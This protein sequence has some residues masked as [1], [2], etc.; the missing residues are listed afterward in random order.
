L[1][2]SS[3]G[4]RY[5]F[6]RKLAEALKTKQARLERAKGERMDRR[7]FTPMRL[8]MVLLVVGL[9]L[10][11]G[12][13]VAQTQSA[14]QPSAD[15]PKSVAQAQEAAQPSGDTPGNAAEKPAETPETPAA[16]AEAA[17]APAADAAAERTL[18]RMR[19]TTQ[20]QREAAAK[21]NAKRRAD[22]VKKGL[23]SA[24]QAI[25]GC[26]APLGTPCSQV[27]YFGIVP[28]YALS[29]LP[30][31]TQ[32][33]AAGILPIV[34]S[35]SGGIRKFMDTLPG[36][37]PAN[38]STLGGQ[39]IP[40]ASPTVNP[41]DPTVSDY[42]EIGLKD[43]T[44]QFHTNLPATTQV[45]GYYDMN[46]APLA[47][48]GNLAD[49]TPHYLG[50]VIIAQGGTALQRRPV[51]IKFVNQ[52][53]ANSFFFIP[54]D[55]SY[56]GMSNMALNGTGAHYS[57][58]RATLHLHGG[59][60]PWISDGTPHQWTVPVAEYAT[61][62]ARTTSD[63]GHNFARGVSAA[64]VP[65]MWFSAAGAAVAA[66][67][68]AS[69]DPGPGMLPF[70]YTNAQ[71]G[72]LMFYHDHSLGITR[73]N[74][75]AG[76]AAGY[77]LH[78][79]TEDALIAA[80]GA[81]GPIP[82]NAGVDKT[83][84]ANLTAAN[85]NVPG[86]LYHFGIPLIIQDKTFV[87]NNTQ[88]TL[89]D[90]SWNWG[91]EGNLWF[92]HVY[93]PN[94]NPN[95]DSGATQN[96]RW[97]YG[98]W[99]WPPLTSADLAHGQQTCLGTGDLALYPGGVCPGTL[100]PSGVPESF[101]D[102]PVVNGVAYPTVTLPQG[103]Y[104]FQ[105]LNAAND[106][107]FNLSLFYAADG[108]GNVCNPSYTG[109][110][111]LGG[112]NAVVATANCTEVKTV[113][114]VPHPQVALAGPALP[115]A[116][117]PADVDDTIPACISS[118]GTPAV[119]LTDVIRGDGF[120]VT[121]NP[122]AFDYNPVTGLPGKTRACWPSSW[123]TD[124]RD[125]G[126]PDPATAGPA[127]V[128]I[129][130]EGGVLPQAVVIPPTPVGYNYNRRDIVVTNVQEHALFLG[131]A[132]RADVIVDFSQVT[133]GSSLLL[134]NDS[135]APVPGYDVR[136]D[137]Y[138]GGPDLSST[139][140]APVTQ[141]GYGPNIRT[142]MQINIVAGSTASY[143]TA[144]TGLAALQTA[145]PGVFQQTQPA[146]IIPQ[147]TYPAA[148][149]SPSGAAGLPVNNTYARIQ[150]TQGLSYTPVN[151]A[152][153]GYDPAILTPLQPKAIHELFEVDYGKMNSILAAE[154]PFTTFTN[155]TT[156]PLAYVDPPTEIV[157]PGQTQ[158]WKVTHNGVDSHAI[159]FHLFDVQLINRV[160]W[161]GAIRP[162][163]PNELGWKETVR[164]NPLEDAIVAL[165]PIKPPIPFTI[166][167]SSRLLDPTRAPGAT[168][169]VA[170]P[171]FSNLDPATGN[172]VTTVNAPYDFG[173]EYV[174]HCH[175]LGHEES[176]MMRPIVF[177]LDVPN[178]PTNLGFVINGPVG[179]P[180]TVT[181][182]WSWTAAPSG[183]ANTG[184][185]VQRQLN[186][187]WV[188]LPAGANV[189]SSPFTDTTVA[190]GSTYFYR[191][192]A[193]NSVLTSQSAA[194]N[195]AGPVVIGTSLAAPTN[196]RQTGIGAGNVTVA[197]TDTNTAG[198]TGFN[199]QR[200]LGGSLLPTP[201]TS[202]CGAPGATFTTVASTGI[203]TFQ[204]RNTGLTPAGQ[205]YTYRVRA[206][207]PAGAVS[208]FS[209]L[210]QVTAQ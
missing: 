141:A 5:R 1:N 150:N 156:L 207:G 158:L 139:G 169:T 191:V 3:L 58:N 200:C 91:N 128:Q 17:E 140:G 76:E 27:N 54:A 59:V 194:S 131:P 129:G 38:P 29:Q 146:I 103:A 26:A 73:L 2:F 121:A 163:D 70:Y 195:V 80:A 168:N 193:L 127:W 74:V 170:Q 89:Q 165:R 203:T 201:A 176:D 196:L 84:V 96:G 189:A 63:G 148:A 132:E 53:A 181:L 79:P 28:N 15:T 138:T 52:L 11:I 40:I 133:A 171:G 8:I 134:Y 209:N 65:D 182:N 206:T 37:G 101:F 143:M 205:L 136:L 7:T 14:A 183:I 104:R 55:D 43:Y 107:M 111:S 175:L 188:T 50:P 115:P 117:T 42:Y 57:Q 118:P 78:D 208:P 114:A 192:Y 126:V 161:D 174:W 75:Y 120:L 137:Y 49:T 152:G 112:A 6:S 24:P 154:L 44:K 166:P 87:P 16:S 21:R 187:I 92:P 31:L 125:G 102:T 33:S 51:R 46:P 61:E 204:F 4:S 106:R 185:M 83:T 99:F 82:N 62:L 25:A 186:G 77:L 155:Q 41:W 162:A 177:K 184:F 197:W 56:M 119:P 45:R 144:P 95:D 108:S 97:D 88:L 93:M 198:A 66:G 164:M 100:N 160:G 172:Q 159:H 23:I 116:E 199:L 39:F 210:L 20:A 124:G 69:N 167:E 13:A 190:P 94:Q 60:T 178:A 122:N 36:L 130:T 18:S 30:T 202:T 113:A 135:P 47:A 145:L 10:G 147:R 179:G 81:L 86:G 173:W 12:L 67:S 72:R 71:S 19:S 34:Y 35:V 149:L 32:T 157:A 90:P 68:G 9:A 109:L 123:P 142:I 48:F 105:I 110:N 180:N 153:T 64:L 151:A 98:P 85:L 22:L